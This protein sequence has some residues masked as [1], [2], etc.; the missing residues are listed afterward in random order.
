MRKVH[1]DGHVNGGTYS[2]GKVEKP[3]SPKAGRKNP[4]KSLKATTRPMKTGC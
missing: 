2:M 3:A 1:F 4:V